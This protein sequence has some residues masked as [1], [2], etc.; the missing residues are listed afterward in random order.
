MRMKLGRRSSF[1]SA[2][3]T[4]FLNEREGGME[5]NGKSSL[6]LLLRKLVE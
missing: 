4:S 2:R 6:M 1:K 5:T 3:K